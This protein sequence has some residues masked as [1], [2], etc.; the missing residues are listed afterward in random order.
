MSIQ[1]DNRCDICEGKKSA[2]GQEKYC[3]RHEPMRFDLLLKYH[4]DNKRQMRE[5]DGCGKEVENLDF[6]YKTHPCGCRAK[7]CREC[8]EKQQQKSG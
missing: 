8:D 5:C 7:F 4:Q 2:P 1:A 3:W 6:V